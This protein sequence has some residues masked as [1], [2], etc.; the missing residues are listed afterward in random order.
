MISLT[1]Q[2]AA[3]MNGSL[4]VEI[5]VSDGRGTIGRSWDVTQ[6]PAYDLS[7]AQLVDFLISAVYTWARR[8]GLSPAQMVGKTVTLDLSAAASLIGIG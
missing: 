2:S 4:E 7:E 1:I 5:A 3:V 8:K 6:L